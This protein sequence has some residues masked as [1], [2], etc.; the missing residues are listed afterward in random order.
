MAFGLCGRTRSLI[1]MGGHSVVTC[2]VQMVGAFEQAICDRPIILFFV[3][4]LDPP[5]TLVGGSG[6]TLTAVLGTLNYA[7][8]SSPPITRCARRSTL[9]SLRHSDARPV[10]P[11]CS[12]S[13]TFDTPFWTPRG[14]FLNSNTGYPNTV[15]QGRLVW[16][17][18]DVDWIFRPVGVKVDVNVS[19]T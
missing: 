16:E 6:E 13:S 14:S 4:P 18:G 7:S 12:R 9:E 8:L 15:A 10:S 2:L 19:A 11:T 3:P 5:C 17:E 1:R